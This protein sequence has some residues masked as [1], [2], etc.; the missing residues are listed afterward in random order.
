MSETLEKYTANGR[1]YIRD[2]G[3]KVYKSHVGESNISN[4]SEGFVPFLLQ[5]T[6]LRNAGIDI[7]FQTDK[8]RIL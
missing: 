4:G 7:D 1:I 5:G 8:Q 3:K 6:E 2:G